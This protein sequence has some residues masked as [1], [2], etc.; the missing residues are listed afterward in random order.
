M[1]EFEVRGNW[2]FLETAVLETVASEGHQ[3]GPVFVI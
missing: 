3:I 1:G 2:I